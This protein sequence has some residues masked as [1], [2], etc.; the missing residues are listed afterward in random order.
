MNPLEHTYVDFMHADRQCYHPY[1]KPDM[2]NYSTNFYRS[3]AIDVIEH[4]DQT[5]PLFLYLP[6]QAVHDPFSDI[7]EGG[8][9]AVPRDFVPAATQARIASEVVGAKRT[10]YAYSLVILDQAVGEIVSTLER[11][12]MM[13]NTYLIFASDNG[14]CYSAGGK[15]GPLRGTKGT[16][17][18]GGT[19]VDAFVYSPL[20]D[21]FWQGA[22]Y[23][24]LMHVSDWFPTMVDMAGVTSFAAR[25]DYPL[26]GVSHFAAWG[27]SSSSSSSS[28]DPPRTHML[29]NAATNVDKQEFDFSTNA[30]FAVRNARY[31]LIHFFDSPAYTSWYDPAV[32]NADDDGPNTSMCSTTS[33]LASLGDFV[34]A[35]FDLQNDPY[36]KVNL[37]D[38]DEPDVVAAK[39]ELYQLMEGLNQQSKRDDIRSYKSLM[40]ATTVWAGADNY[41][42]P[43]LD[44]GSDYYEGVAAS[45]TYPLLCVPMTTVY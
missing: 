37:F 16:L 38:S 3:K 4:H 39:A 1:D 34:F 42:V 19:K 23:D 24:H 17:L 31:K 21:S 11:L 32:E 36:E 5:V 6:F 26:D 15:N 41:I 13:D 14:G 35:L 20:L 40:T 18:E 10:E 7:R 12:Q 9:G 28:S 2:Y 8:D 27:G 22:S 44:A 43:Y 33:P 45:G 25:P 30:P 29:Y